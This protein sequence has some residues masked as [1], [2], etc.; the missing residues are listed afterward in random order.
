MHRFPFKLKQANIDNKIRSTG[1]VYPGPVSEIDIPIL[2]ITATRLIGSKELDYE[3]RRMVFKQQDIQ[4]IDIF[5]QER[6]L[7]P[8]KRR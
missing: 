8:K 1:Q 5:Q 7:V 2:I 3:T 4:T 6:R